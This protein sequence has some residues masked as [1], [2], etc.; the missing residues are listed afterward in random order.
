MGEGEPETNIE[1]KRHMSNTVFSTRSYEDL[2]ADELF[3]RD[4]IKLLTEGYSYRAI[5]EHYAM[6]H[7]TMMKVARVVPRYV[8]EETVALAAV[9]Q[10]T[11]FDRLEQAKR[12]ILPH[13]VDD[14]TNEPP[15]PKQVAAYVRLVMTELA[16]LTLN[17]GQMSLPEV[18]DNDG[19]VGKGAMIQRYSELVEKMKQGVLEAGYGDGTYEIT[20]ADEMEAEVE[21]RADNSGTIE[22]ALVIDDS[23]TVD[24][25]LDSGPGTW[26]DGKWVPNNG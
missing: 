23:A 11:E 9:W 3:M 2:V 17:R 14:G 20:E 15:N 4:V 19:D 7:Q 10:G 6:S 16:V 13:I 25:D 18:V 12:R 21:E 8:A 26:V 1:A 5:E 24:T 22:D